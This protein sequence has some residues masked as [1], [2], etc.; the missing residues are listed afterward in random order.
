MRN[1]RCDLPHYIPW[2]RAKMSHDCRRLTQLCVSLRRA[3]IPRMNGSGRME[4]RRGRIAWIRMKRTRV[5]WIE[6][7]AC[8]FLIAVPRNLAETRPTSGAALAVNSTPALHAARSEPSD[9]ELAG[10]LVGL[11]PG[12]TRYVTRADLLSLPQ[13]SSTVTDDPNFAGAA[14]TGGS[15]GGANPPIPVRIGGV[16]LEDLA[17]R[18]AAD[19]QAEMVVAV[20]TDLYRASYPRDYLAAHHPLLVLTI[21]GKPPSGWPKDPETH[22]RDMGPYLISHA[23]F[24]PAFKLFS[25]ADEALIPWGVVRLEFHKESA[26]FGA[27]IPRGPQ[28]SVELVQA[29][30][31]I[32]RQNCF[33]CHNAG[34]AGGTKAGHP[35]LV[36]SAWAAASPEYFAAYVR[37]PRSR[38]PN[39][40]MPGNPDYDDATLRA[41]MAYFK[42]FSTWQTAEKP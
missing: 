6:F 12:T 42:A 23:R 2:F 3:G 19:S 36:L 32:A 30:Y 25:H 24:T 34:D 26:V 41:L 31:R 39:S 15:G 37:D 16:L 4:V 14:Q 22:E 7:I 17:R 5:V 33:R 27:I 9:L 13:I 21:D 1:F 8:M 40:Q 35:W 18:F 20:C 38:N 11:P 29:G 28:A 10:D